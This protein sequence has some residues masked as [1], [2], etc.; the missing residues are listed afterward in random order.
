MF[1]PLNSGATRQSWGGQLCGRGISWRWL[2]PGRHVPAAGRTTARMGGGLASF[3]GGTPRLCPQ[4][5]NC[6][7]LAS[8]RGDTPRAAGRTTAR[9]GGGL[10]SFRGGTPR[11]CSHKAKWGGL[12]SFRGDTPRAA[13]RTTARMGGGWHHSGAARPGG[14]AEDCADGRRL[15]SFRGGTP[16]LCF[17]DL[18]S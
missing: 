8:F 15:A 10:A 2:F 5:A 3:R 14:G 12:A 6:G 13:G 11:L 1:W 18:A 4:K 7:G 16:R 9:M 17:G